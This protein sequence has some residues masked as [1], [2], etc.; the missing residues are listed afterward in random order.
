[1]A[2]GF[3]VRE[4]GWEAELDQWAGAMN[5]SFG[6]PPEPGAR[7]INSTRTFIQYCERGQDIS[8]VAV[9]EQGVIAS[10]ALC[11]IDPV[12]KLGEFDPVGTRPSFRRMGLARTVM[13]TLG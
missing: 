1:M 8:L 5:E 11:L 2:A 12:T 9:S 6:G 4:S 3:A 7:A 10:Y 13:L